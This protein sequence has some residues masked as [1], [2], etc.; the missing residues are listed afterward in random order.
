MHRRRISIGTVIAL[1]LAMLTVGGSLWIFAR[2]SGTNV[3]LALTSR[4]ALQVESAPTGS[5]EK[6]LLSGSSR[7]EQ[8][9]ATAAPTEAPP[10]E[11]FTLCAAGTLA[12]E[13]NIRKSCYSQDSAKYD[14]T[15]V[16]SLLREETEA[17]IRAVFLENILQDDAK[18]TRTV[19][20]AE[21]A[22]MPRSAGFLS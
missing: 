18:V 4:E 13:E 21:A 20:P 2:L 3:S 6:I 17:D 15:E 16:L 14:F 1:S 10:R 19:L 22:R 12:I 9:S 7:K 11:S 8:P 5:P